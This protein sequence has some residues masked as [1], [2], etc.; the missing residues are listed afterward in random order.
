MTNSRS[1]FTGA[2]AAGL[3]LTSVVLVGTA[4]R[5]YGA[6]PAKKGTITHLKAKLTGPAIDG[7]DPEGH[8]MYLARPDKGTSLLVVEVDH[9]K[10]PADTELT[11]DVELPGDASPTSVGSIKLDAAGAGVLELNSRDGATVPAIVTGTSVSV[12]NAG[13]MILTGVF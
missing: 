3:L 6:D 12:N 5:A 1:V 8:A 11:V 4:S 10:L 9:V 2:V 13:T 7:V